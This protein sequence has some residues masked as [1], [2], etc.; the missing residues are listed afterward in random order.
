MEIFRV[1][2]RG[3]AQPYRI[4]LNYTPLYVC[5][6]YVLCI[7]LFKEAYICTW[8]NQKPNNLQQSTLLVQDNLYLLILGS[9]CSTGMYELALSSHLLP[10]IETDEHQF[11]NQ[12]IMKIMRHGFSKEVHE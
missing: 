6:V 4:I 11:E 2:L 5:V 3:R 10:Q 1:S 7:H 9:T 8:A 12:K